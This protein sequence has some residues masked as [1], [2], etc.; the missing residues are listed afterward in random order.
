MT[1]VWYL[2]GLEQQEVGQTEIFSLPQLFQTKED[3]IKASD[4]C[5][6]G[7]G[8]HKSYKRG[9]WVKPNKDEFYYQENGAGIRFDIFPLDVISY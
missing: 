8:L 5:W 2:R 6:K 1:K 3:A 7:W 9:K 4:K